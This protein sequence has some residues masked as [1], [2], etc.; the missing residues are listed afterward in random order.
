MAKIVVIYD[1]RTGNTKRMAECV[2]E[3]IEESGGEVTIK[4]VEEATPDDLYAADGIAIG[5]PTY[6]GHC[7]SQIRRL[8]DRSVQYHGRL[9][10]KVGGAFASS[11]HIGGGNETTVLAIL[12]SMLVHGMII[13]G[14]V[15]G[16]HYGPTSIGAPNRRSE[17]QCRNLGNR[18]VDL[19]ERLAADKD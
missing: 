13:Q 3:G 16:D 19:S 1:S 11:H 9:V 17:R 6:Y 4:S 10:G 15:D 18:L 14:V 8:F 12:H 7:T 5:S 2:A